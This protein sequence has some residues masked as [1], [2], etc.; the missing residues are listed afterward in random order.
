MNLSIRM[1]LNRIEP[2]P[3]FIVH[4]P[5]VEGGNDTCDYQLIWAARLHHEMTFALPDGGF[6]QVNLAFMTH[7]T[8]KRPHAFIIA[9]HED[10]EG[11]WQEFVSCDEVLDCNGWE[12]M[13][14]C[15]K[16]HSVESGLDLSITNRDG[17]CQLTRHWTGIP[18]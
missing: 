11:C 9:S 3:H 4:A 10:H 12:A 2:E 16:E 1:I 17:F 8:T 6:H 14:A 13:V 15:L 18:A 5:N 7:S